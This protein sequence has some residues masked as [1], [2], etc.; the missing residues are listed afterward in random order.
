LTL[1]ALSALMIAFPLYAGTLSLVMPPVA[2]AQELP[3]ADPAADNPDQRATWT[4]EGQTP[5]VEGPTNTPITPTDDVGTPTETATDDPST[6]TETPSETP[7]DGGPTNTPTE[8]PTEGS[9]TPTET[10]S[11][12]PTEGSAT[13]TETAT[14]TPTQESDGRITVE[15][16]ASVDDAQVGQVFNYS[17]SVLT[18]STTEIAVT[19]TDDVPSQL[20]VLSAGASP[21]SCNVNGQNVSCTMNITQDNPAVVSIQVRITVPELTSLRIRT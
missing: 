7:T 8:T 2:P 20:E 18:T 11:E 17:V 21:G 9:A 15:K 6:P 12:T 1:I 4:P 13:P 10:P 5:T 14:S 16:I 3:S 19:M